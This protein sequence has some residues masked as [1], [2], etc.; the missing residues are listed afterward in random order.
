ML[1]HAS[2]ADFVLMLLGGYF[3]IFYASAS[4]IIFVWFIGLMVKIAW[5]SKKESETETDQP[6]S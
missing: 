1:A 3:V 6:P 5:S 2:S 4:F